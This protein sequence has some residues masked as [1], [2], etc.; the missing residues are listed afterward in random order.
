MG[1]HRR[2]S[3]PIYRPG[4]VY[5]RAGMLLIV[6]F[7]IT[8][9]AIETT[10]L[11]HEWIWFSIFCFFETSLIVLYF[12]IVNSWLTWINQTSDYT[13]VDISVDC[14]YG[15]DHHPGEHCNP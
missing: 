9:A 4:S 6:T 10:Y 12:W 1:K 7:G 2:T 14:A 11:R 5:F 8:L 15:H 13:F 3:T